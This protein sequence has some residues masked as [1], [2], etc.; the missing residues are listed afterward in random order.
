MLMNL[1]LQGLK[2]QSLL[3][4]TQV[5]S[6]SDCFTDVAILKTSS[7][8]ITT[9]REV[10]MYLVLLAGQ[11]LG[12]HTVYSRNGIDSSAGMIGSCTT[13]LSSF[14]SIVGQCGLDLF[15]LCSV[16]VRTTSENDGNK[17]LKI[18][19]FL[20]LSPMMLVHVEVRLKSFFKFT[21]ILGTSTGESKDLYL[22]ASFHLLSPTI[23]MNKC[24]DKT[25]KLCFHG[26][27]VH[28]R[29]PEGPRGV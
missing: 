20:L 5:S 29:T 4:S 6:C 15:S 7:S 26:Y 23:K 24:M 3:R 14:L 12:F 8:D 18:L 9:W 21:N 16:G 10:N 1:L 22:S 27:P 25:K 28:R 19:L 11:R 13:T 17:S 2:H